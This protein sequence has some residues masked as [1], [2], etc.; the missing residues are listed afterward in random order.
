MAYKYV[1]RN[2]LLCLH[3]TCIWH[4]MPYDD[5]NNVKLIISDM[6]SKC[7]F[8]DILYS[9]TQ[10]TIFGLLL[11]H[12]FRLKKSTTPFLLPCFPC[13]WNYYYSLWTQCG[14]S[15]KLDLCMT[16]NFCCCFNNYYICSVILK[17][18]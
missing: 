2:M 10:W 7:C 4:V 18:L 3:S 14:G 13:K 17:N 6:D 9:L 1:R 8:L 5:I 11:T 16:T 12:F 15:S